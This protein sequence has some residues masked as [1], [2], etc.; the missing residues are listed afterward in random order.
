MIFKGAFVFNPVLTQAIGICPIVAVAYTVKAAVM[1]SGTLA[2]LMLLC[3]YFSAFVLYKL[4]RW[5]RVVCY[6]AFSTALLSAVM[7]VLDVISPETSSALGVYLPLLSVNSLVV[8]RCEKFA[9]KST[10]GMKNTQKLLYCL[11]DCASA[12]V[13]YAA[14]IIIVAFIRQQLS[15]GK[16]LG[17]GAGVLPPLSVMATPFG[18]LVVLCF[19]AAVHKA[20]IKKFFPDEP[21]EVFDFSSALKMPLVYDPGIRA[22]DSGSKLTQEPFTRK[23]NLRIRGIEINKTEADIL[24]YGSDFE[25]PFADYVPAETEYVIREGYDFT[26]EDVEF[27]AIPVEEENI[28]QED[29]ET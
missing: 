12:C 2:V 25:D 17:F 16:F 20:I 5:L 6:L 7:P 8:I 26:D 11:I 23:D 13:G 22:R 9:V 1:L 18:G 19:V 10:I 4:P 29:G 14:V 15:A 24:F 27:I 3:E 28:S 21:T